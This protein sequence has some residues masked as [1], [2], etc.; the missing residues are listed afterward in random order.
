MTCPHPFDCRCT[1]CQHLSTGGCRL[2][3]QDQDS[4]M[5]MRKNARLM[6][7]LAK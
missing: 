6:E 7:M 3:T 5:L 1:G 2:P 4:E